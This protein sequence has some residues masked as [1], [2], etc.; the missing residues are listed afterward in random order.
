VPIPILKLGEKNWGDPTK[1]KVREMTIVEP[2]RKLFGSSLPESLQYWSLC[3]QLGSNGTLQSGCE[4]DYVV[5]RGLVTPGQFHGIE[6][7]PEIF[8]ENQKC[9][10][11]KYKCAHL[12]QG[13]FT[14]VLDQALGEKTLRPGIV[15]LDAIQCPEGALD[16][17]ATTLDILN[18]VQCP[19]ILTWN[20]VKGNRYQGRDYSWDSIIQSAKKNKLFQKSLSSWNQLD[21][22]KVF[23]YPGTGRSCTTMASVVLYRK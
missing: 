23:E 11:G 12:Y 20:F 21:D 14:D 13:E 16:L 10:T 2:Y 18:C 1:Q 4:L 9:L 7:N 15:Y 3:G 22:G 5:S 8:R 17:L 19:T 6:G